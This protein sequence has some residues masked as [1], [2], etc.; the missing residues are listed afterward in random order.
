M[1][2]KIL[3][4]FNIFTILFWHQTLYV[5]LTRV[6]SHYCLCHCSMTA[7][8]CVD[9]TPTNILKLVLTGLVLQFF[10][11]FRE[12]LAA[13][14]N[15]AAVNSNVYMSYNYNEYGQVGKDESVF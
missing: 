1:A 10:C 2:E 11:Y 5:V 15:N 4:R 12:W 13:T 3:Q 6:F 9:T 8:S 14:Y 7:I